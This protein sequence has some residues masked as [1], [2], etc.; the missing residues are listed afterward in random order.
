MKVNRTLNSL[1]ITKRCFS[2]EHFS[3]LWA[4]SRMNTIRS[5]SPA[6]THLSISCCYPWRHD[7]INCLVISGKHNQLSEENNTPHGTEYTTIV[8]KESQS[9]SL[10]FWSLV[11]PKTFMSDFFYP[12]ILSRAFPLVWDFMNSCMYHHQNDAVCFFQVL[13]RAVFSPKY[14]AIDHCK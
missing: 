6:L 14:F 2:W 13:Q 1:P 5:V 7:L 11:H 10:C 3:S 4:H 9:S 8:S 12:W